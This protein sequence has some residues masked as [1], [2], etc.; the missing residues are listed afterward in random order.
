[1]A[2]T[3]TGNEFKTELAGAEVGSGDDS[4]TLIFAAAL[5]EADIQ[6]INNI[7]ATLS[8]RMGTNLGGGPTAATG[9]NG[10]GTLRSRLSTRES[11]LLPALPY[12]LDGH[13]PCNR[14]VCAG[15]VVG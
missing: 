1:M 7:R 13:G 12:F 14:S 3:T 4:T 5:T 9:E 8:N 6:G 10:A 2:T 11:A 15:S